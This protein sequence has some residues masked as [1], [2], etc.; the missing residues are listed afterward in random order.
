MAFSTGTGPQ[1]VLNTTISEYIKERENNIMRKRAFLALLKESGRISYGHSGEKMEWPV[2]YKRNSMIGQGHFSSNS[3]AQ[4]NRHTTASLP[5]R[6]YILPE[7]LDKFSR[8]KNRGK[9]AI[10][11]LY[12][13]IVDDMLDDISDQ[14]CAKLF[15]DGNASGNELEIHGLDSFAGTSGVTAAKYA[16][17]SDTYGGL[18]TVLGNYGGSWTGTWPFGSGDAQYDFWT[19]LLPDWSDAGWVGG[20]TTWAANAVEVLRWG[21]VAQQRNKNKLDC[22]LFEGDLFR[23]FLDTLDDKERIIVRENAKNGKMP[24]LGFGEAVMFDGV[25]CIWEFGVASDVVYGVTLKDIEIRSMQKQMFVAN[26]EDFDMAT[27]SHRFSIDFYGNARFNP[28]GMA[29]VDSYT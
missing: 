10:I 1:S 11:D 26:A 14:F 9:E 18:S 6:S 13:T 19:P 25:E 4:Q 7:G 24:S 21:I 23:Q 29:R 20:L 8:L 2:R 12:A 15:V 16:T 28:R 17:A 3:F 22:Y 27:S 5:W